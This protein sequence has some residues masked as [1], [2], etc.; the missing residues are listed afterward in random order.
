V[1]AATYP[2]ANVYKPAGADTDLVAHS[3]P[4][5]YSNGWRDADY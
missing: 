1:D 3:L 4:Y 2:N 5:V